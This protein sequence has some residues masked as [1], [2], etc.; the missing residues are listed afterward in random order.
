MIASPRVLECV[1]LLTGISVDELKR[2]PI[3]DLRLP[4]SYDSLDRVE[5]IM[6]LQEEFGKETV[7]WAVRYI[8]ASEE[9]HQTRRSWGLPGAPRASGEHPLWDRDLDA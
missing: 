8:E 9:R 7:N 1:S 5:L 4:D 2:Q 3:P 6:E